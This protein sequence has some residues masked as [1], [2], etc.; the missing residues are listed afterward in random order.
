MT[1][2]ASF[3]VIHGVVGG[4]RLRHGDAVLCIFNE[5]FDPRGAA[6]GT[7]TASPVVDRT[8]TGDRP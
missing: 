8:V 2:G 4:L 7:G 3:V 6:T 5:A 1:S